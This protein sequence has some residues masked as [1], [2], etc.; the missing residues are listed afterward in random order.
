MSVEK[1]DSAQF[2]QG[3]AAYARGATLRGLVEQAAR[4]EATQPDNEDAIPSLLIGFGE[5]LLA[6]IRKIRACMAS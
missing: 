2:D 1:I 6:D 3:V 5:G 4:L